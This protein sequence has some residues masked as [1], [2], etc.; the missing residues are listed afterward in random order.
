MSQTEVRSG[1]QGRVPGFWS[2]G[3]PTRVDGGRQGTY[4]MIRDQ[5]MNIMAT[6][7]PTNRKTTAEV[8]NEDPNH[9]VQ[10][11]VMSNSKVA[12]IMCYEHDLMPEETQEYSRRDVPLTSQGEYKTEEQNQVAYNLWT[13]VG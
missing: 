1:C 12:C 6:L 5:M 9:H 8:R 2:A 11:E 3:L 10:F 7:P 13:V 4:R